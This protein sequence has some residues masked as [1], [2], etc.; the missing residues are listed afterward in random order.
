MTNVVPFPDRLQMLLDAPSDKSFIEG[1]KLY[2]RSCQAERDRIVAELEAR[3]A[4]PGARRESYM[5][6]LSLL[7]YIRGEMRSKPPAPPQD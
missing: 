1:V 3:E 5:L 7:S 2:D 4:R 6:C